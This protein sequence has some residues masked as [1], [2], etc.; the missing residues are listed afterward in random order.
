MPRMDLYLTT[1]RDSLLNHGAADAG[2]TRS[3]YIGVLLDDDEHVHRGG[4]G[5][6]PLTGALAEPL[7]PIAEQVLKVKP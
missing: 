2:L 1:R 7:P 3:Q 4:P 6:R 5:G